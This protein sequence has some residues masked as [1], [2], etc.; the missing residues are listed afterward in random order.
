M[1]LPTK[2]RVPDRRAPRAISLA[3]ACAAAAVPLLAQ[4]QIDQDRARAYF[5]EA[6]ALCEREGGRLWG[7]SLCGP[8]V[9][10]DAATQSIATS[11]PA[12]A[13]NRP[14]MLGF[15][16]APLEWGGTRWAAYVWSLI[17]ADDAQA[18]GRLL[19]H[20]LFHRVQPQ[21]G[22]LT[23]GQPNDHLDTL[24]GRYWLR[25]EWRALARALGTTG[26][27]RTDAM[28][29]ALAFRANRRALFDDA[30]EREHNDE[31]REGMAQYTGT[32]AATQSHEE[33]VASAIRQLSDYAE[34]A[35]YVRVFGYPSGTAYGLLLDAATP[36]WRRRLRPTDDL[37][38]LL[39][40]ATGARPADDAAAAATRYDGAAL[41]AAEEKRD[42][43]H[44]AR[45]AELRRRFVDGPVLVVPRGRNAMLMTTGATPIPGAGTVFFQYRVTGEWGS[46][47]STGVLE[48]SDGSTLSLPA[49]FRTDGATLEGEGWTITLAPGWVVRPAERTGDFMVG[50]EARGPASRL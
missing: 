19:L 29:D 4:A 27:E 2:R 17:P 10:A 3:A 34:N 38:D 33:A 23:I 31:I 6:Q 35:T 14:R 39:I 47:E 15:V 41:R 22:L 13:A 40:E 21:L 43:E 5:A 12:P 32:V 42:A 20:E 36:D 50:R 26:A 48:S 9:F 37:G 44:R 8:M 25:L 28:R 45:V 7:V 16:N 24:E 46:L 1:T 11:E 49:P 30:A 18:R